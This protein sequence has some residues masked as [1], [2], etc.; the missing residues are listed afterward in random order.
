MQ[1]KIAFDFNFKD[2]MKETRTSA[3]KEMTKQYEKAVSER[4]E[5]EEKQKDSDSDNFS[6]DWV[7]N[8]KYENQRNQLLTC[9]YT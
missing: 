1:E 8:F 4:D 7:N 6:N 2:I 5:E 3:I 9:R